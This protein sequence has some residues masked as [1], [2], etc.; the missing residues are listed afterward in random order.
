M[1]PPPKEALLVNMRLRASRNGVQKRRPRLRETEGYRVWDVASSRWYAAQTAHVPSG[2]LAF[3]RQPHGHR[4]LVLVGRMGG[5][6]LPSYESTWLL[7]G[8]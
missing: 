4:S 5:S 8:C 1:P 6:Q 2:R 3:V 7:R